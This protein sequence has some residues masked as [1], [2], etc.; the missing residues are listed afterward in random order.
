MYEVTDIQ[1]SYKFLAPLAGT[2]WASILFGGCFS[3]SR[4]KFNHNRYT[5]RSGGDGRLFEFAHRTL[6]TQIDHTANSN[7]S[8][9]ILLSFFMVK[10]KREALLVFS[11]VILSLQL[12]FAV[13][14]LIHFTSDKEK[15]GGFCNQK[16]DEDLWPGGIAAIIISLNVKLVLQ[17]IVHWLD[18]SG[19][20]QWMIWIFVIPFCLAIGAL[21]LYI[22]FKPLLDQRRQD[23]NII[24]HGTATDLSKLEQP[25][26]KRIAIT[27]DF[28]SVDAQNDPKCFS[29]GRKGRVP[30]Y[31]YT[32]LKR[33]EPCGM[34]VRLP[35]VRPMRMQ[36]G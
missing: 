32:L 15:M 26:Y 7:H 2:E 19:K 5:C 9:L 34:E 3:C 22:A 30:I 27:I 35:T 12:G 31:C 23:K 11:Q 18:S 8:Q 20:N 21:L 25:V 29:P 1:D 33:P 28:S 13:I 4:T 6:V 16:L 10:E 17:E 36:L 14:P 24:P